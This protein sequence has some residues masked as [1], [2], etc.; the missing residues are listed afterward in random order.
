MIFKMKNIENKTTPTTWEM[1]K[2]FAVLAS[3]IYGDFEVLKRKDNSD[4][5]S[6]KEKWESF[7]ALK[8]IGYT[9]LGSIIYSIF[10]R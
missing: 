2:D 4:N 3:P 9:A 6:I 10:S 8:Y 1:I 5:Q 7:L